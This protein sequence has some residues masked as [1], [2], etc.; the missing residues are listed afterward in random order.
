M[1]YVF[2]EERQ[3][4]RF[5]NKITLKEVLSEESH[6]SV[7]RVHDLFK[8]YHDEGCSRLEDLKTKLES[9]AQGGDDSGILKE[10]EYL[11]TRG[12]YLLAKEREEVQTVIYLPRFSGAGAVARPKE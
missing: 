3:E 8:A 12:G 5:Q 4:N 1:R 7:K 6:F 10:G 2:R 9:V 11:A